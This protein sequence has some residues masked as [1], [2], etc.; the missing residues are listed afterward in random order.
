[1]IDV[2]IAPPTH[3]KMLSTFMLAGQF[4]VKYI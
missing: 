4:S 2:S 3:Y 1:M